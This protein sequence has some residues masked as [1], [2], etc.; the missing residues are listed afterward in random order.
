MLYKGYIAGIILSCFIFLI[1]VLIKKV[2]HICLKEI[3]FSKRREKSNIRNYIQK[4]S[5]WI[6]TF[7]L[8]ILFF[9]INGKTTEISFLETKGENE[10]HKEIL[11]RDELFEILEEYY[12]VRED[13]DDDNL[14][15]NEDKLQLQLNSFEKEIEN[16]N[17]SIRDL[18]E[19]TKKEKVRQNR[20]LF[21]NGIGTIVIPVLICLLNIYSNEIKSKLKSRKDVKPEN[22]VLEEEGD[23]KKLVGEIKK[24]KKESE[25]CN[26]QSKEVELKNKQA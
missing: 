7:V 5:A 26:I 1:V 2:R 25:S 11:S 19:T 4:L 23:S 18:E 12:Y 24:E 17:D 6:A 3:I 14:S 21:V 13:I 8:V 22:D 9:L 10:L 16:L 20:E 15:E